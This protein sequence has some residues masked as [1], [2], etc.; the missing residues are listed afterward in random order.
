MYGLERLIVE[1]L[2]QDSLML[3]NFKIA[4]LVSIIMIISGIII[5]IYSWRKN[6]DRCNNK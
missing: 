2:R 1:S 4:Q 3:G 5:P 6:N